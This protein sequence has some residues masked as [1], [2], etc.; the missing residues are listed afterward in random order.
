MQHLHHYCWHS[1]ACFH[2]SDGMHKPKFH[3]EILS[4]RSTDLLSVSSWLPT[5]PGLLSVCPVQEGCVCVLGA[6][7]AGAGA[8]QL[9]CCGSLLSARSRSAR[10]EPGKPRLL[11]LWMPCLL[12]APLLAPAVLL[13]CLQLRSLFQLRNVFFCVALLSFANPCYLCLQVL[14]CQ[15]FA[16][17]GFLSRNWTA[18]SD[19][20]VPT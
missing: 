12:S 3:P 7:L 1:V 19:I 17:A 16:A 15:H 18:L 9:G 6:G 8:V 11:G 10:P 5:Q 2:F 14:P 13:R 20:S 4:H